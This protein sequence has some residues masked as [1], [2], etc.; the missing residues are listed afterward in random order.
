MIGLVRETDSFGGHA[1]QVITAIQIMSAVSSISW[2][3]YFIYLIVW[4]SEISTMSSKLFF[5]TGK[6]WKRF[7]KCILLSKNWDIWKVTWY[8]AG[9]RKTDSDGLSSTW[10]NWNYFINDRR[11][12]D[13]DHMK[14]TPTFDILIASGS[15][16]QHDASMDTISYLMHLKI[17]CYRRYT[18]KKFIKS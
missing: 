2:T 17:G 15:K 12:K 3:R 6:M 7:Y 14:L 9:W 4:K 16:S 5:C 8:L 13:V 1:R 10:I 18:A 11:G